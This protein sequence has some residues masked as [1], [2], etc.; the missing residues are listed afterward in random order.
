M[1]FQKDNP[2]RPKGSLNKETKKTKEILNDFLDEISPAMIEYAKT[3][4]PEKQFPIWKELLC[5]RVGKMSNV[6]VTTDGDS[7]NRNVVF[8]FPLVKKGDGV[9]SA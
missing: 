4:P 9:K 5:Y 8:N 6:D 7:L 3:L 2:G 1:P